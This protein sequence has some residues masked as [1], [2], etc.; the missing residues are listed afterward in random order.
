M[1]RDGHDHRFEC[2]RRVP[3]FDGLSEADQHRIADA[4]V[5]RRYRP[6]EQI[7][8]VGDRTGLHIIHRGQVKAYRLTDT[9]S[10]QLIRLLSPGEFLGESALIADTAADHYAVTTRSSEVCLV[11]RARMRQL[12]VEHPRIA[13]QMLQTVSQRLELAEEMLLALSGRSVGQRLAQQ[14]LQL[15][16]EG[17]SLRFRLPTSQKDLASYLGTS[18]ETLSRRLRALQRAGIIRLGP[19][20]AVEILDRPRLRELTSRALPRDR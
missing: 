19:R 12:L 9:G 5:T 1:V 17:H 11:P 14:L 18:P 3:I 10:E 4:A 8:G 2:V 7:Y 20:R 16:D 6:H 15:A 13:L